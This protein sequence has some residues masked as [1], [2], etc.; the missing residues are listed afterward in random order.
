MPG[1]GDLATTRVRVLEGELR[2]L[3][4]GA[5]HPP[6]LA[7]S[8]VPVKE[9]PKEGAKEVPEG[10][11][12][13]EVGAATPPAPGKE[14]KS[15]VKST[16]AAGLPEEEKGRESSQELKSRRRRTSKLHGGEEAKKRKGERPPEPSNP[17][18]WVG[19]SPGT[20]HVRKARGPGWV[21]PV[22]LTRTTPFWHQGRRR[23][24]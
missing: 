16:T 20:T 21:G 9:E 5:A 22:P 24:H 6:S 1:F 8:P 23:H 2:D 19:A 13:F 12:A 17:P 4:A 15:P 10:L 3:L 7:P 18:T 11:T 14:D